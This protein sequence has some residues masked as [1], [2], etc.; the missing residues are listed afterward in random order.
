MRTQ[1]SPPIYAQAS[2]FKMLCQY[3][4]TVKLIVIYVTQ[5]SRYYCRIAYAVRIRRRGRSR[6]I[7][8]QSRTLESDR[9][10]GLSD[11][12]FDRGIPAP[13]HGREAGGDR[14]RSQCDV[15]RKDA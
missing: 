4:E 13:D 14:D 1:D 7:E 6:K 11:S 12:G 2:L 9:S 10:D 15:A 8:K 5:S 3:Q